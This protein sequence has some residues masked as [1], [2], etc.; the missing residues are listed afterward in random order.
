MRLHM[1]RERTRLR[2][3]L[4]ANP[5]PIRLF[6]RVNPQVNLQGGRLIKPFLAYPAYVVPIARVSLHVYPKILAP[7]KSFG[8]NRTLI[9]F[10]PRMDPY[11]FFQLRRADAAPAAFGADVRF[12]AAVRPRV[13]G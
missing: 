2:K 1:R 8:T 4:I 9:R 7:G 12:L 10:F 5:T 11:V 3:R 13:D 6:P